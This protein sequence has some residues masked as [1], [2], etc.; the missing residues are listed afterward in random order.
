MGKR[1]LQAAFFCCLAASVPATLFAQSR[2]EIGTVVT[3]QGSVS[4]RDP[5][6]AVRNAERRGDIYEGDTII[7][8]DA[9]FVSLRMVDNAHLSLGPATEFMFSAYRFD[10][11]PGTKDSVVMNLLRGCFR[12]TVGSAGSG[13]RDEYR[14]ETPVA[15]IDV[16]AS[17]HGAAMLGDRLY[18]A[19]WDGATVVSN[20]IGTLNLGNYGDYEYSRTLPGQA[21]RGLLALVPEAAC[22]P[23]EAFDGRVEPY[24]ITERDRDEDDD[25]GDR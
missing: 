23:P 24:R 1:S 6:G 4:V 10:G 18:T 7:V 5:S 22:E 13:R 25:E 8:A 15:N 16:D 14:V 20:T 2:K 21:P 11:K 17:F 12:T 3:T 9:G 19:T